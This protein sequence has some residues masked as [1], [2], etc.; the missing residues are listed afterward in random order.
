MHSA[1]LTATGMEG[2]KQNRILDPAV[3]GPLLQ[4]TAGPSA[5]HRKNSG[6]LMPLAAQ[7][8][9]THRFVV[10]TQRERGFSLGT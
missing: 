4:G 7:S 9:G 6:V 10:V 5:T 8:I 2:A 3:L 1:E